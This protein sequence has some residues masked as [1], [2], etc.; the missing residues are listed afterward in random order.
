LSSNSRRSCYL[1]FADIDAALAHA[2]AEIR[3]DHAR[4]TPIGWHHLAVSDRGMTAR[5]ERKAMIA[6]I[7]GVVVPLVGVI[8]TGLVVYTAWTAR[9]VEKRLPPPRTFHRYRRRAYSLPR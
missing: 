4:D 1:T 7:V 5:K 3:A 6:W 2:A 9:Q 8:V